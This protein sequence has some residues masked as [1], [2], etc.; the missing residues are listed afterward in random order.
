MT[1][2]WVART[3]RRSAPRSPRAATIQPASNT[4]D[5]PLAGCLA[6]LQDEY[7]VWGDVTSGVVQ[8]GAGNTNLDQG[9][10]AGGNSGAFANGFTTGPDAFSTAFSPSTNTVN[11]VL[12]QRWFASTVANMRLLDDTGNQVAATA[13]S[14]AIIGS[15][16]APGA[17]LTTISFT[18]DISGARSLWLAGPSFAT[19][20]GA[21]NVP[22][23]LAPATA[24]KHLKRKHGHVK[25]HHVV[26][27]HK[28]AKR[29]GHHALK[30]AHH[31]VA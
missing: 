23:Q 25:W 7:I 28:L 31:R 17:V 24:T 14:A 10:P 12:D 11:V 6:N 5:V 20:T 13:T 9:V 18:G 8:T 4:V 30:V 16:Q 26:S 21:I 2:S 29:F 3:G 1:S 19:A 27:R 22:Q 15:N